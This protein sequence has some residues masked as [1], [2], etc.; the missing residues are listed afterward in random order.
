MKTRDVPQDVPER[1]RCVSV[2][3]ISQGD[4]GGD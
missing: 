3:R 2:G 1:Y 4:G